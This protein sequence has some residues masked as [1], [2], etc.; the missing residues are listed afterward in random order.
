MKENQ[1]PME[2]LK[3]LSSLLSDLKKESSRTPFF[4]MPLF[5]FDTLPDKVFEKITDKPNFVVT[6]TPSWAQQLQ[7][8]FWQPSTA[9]ALSTMILIIVAGNFGFQQQAKNNVVTP[10]LAIHE[11][12][13][14]YVTANLDDFEEEL[15]AEY[16]ERQE[17][18]DFK[19]NWTTE[20]LE[21][22]LNEVAD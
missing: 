12:V 13:H 16:H 9:W 20:E 22:F 17:D 8:W 14:Q 15:L 6:K 2:E 4:K 7:Q 10:T 1:N 21:H 11:E 19:S 18:K 3:D 5:Y